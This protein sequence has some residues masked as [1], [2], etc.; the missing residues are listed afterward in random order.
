MTYAVLCN[1]L[2]FEYYGKI[3]EFKKITKTGTTAILKEGIW[4]FYV[5]ERMFLLKTWRHILE[6]MTD[7]GYEFSQQYKQ[8]LTP[9]KVAD[10]QKGLIEQLEYLINE[11]CDTYYKKN[12][13][14]DMWLMRIN[15]EQIEILQILMLTSDQSAFTTK[16]FTTILRLFLKNYF[17]NQPAFVECAKNSMERDVDELLQAQISCYLVLFENFW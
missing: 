6:Y 14:K 7:A 3:K 10:L 15:R 12:T 13:C 5:A 8:F 2:M 9:A 16:Q 11:I 4:S 1:Y 17:I